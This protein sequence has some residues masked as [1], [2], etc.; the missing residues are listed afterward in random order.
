MTWEVCRHFL[1][2][3]MWGYWE[4]GRAFGGWLEVDEVLSVEPSWMGTAP[5]HRSR[6]NLLPRLALPWEDTVRRRL[7]ATRGRTVSRAEL[8]PSCHTWLVSWTVGSNCLLVMCHPVGG[9]LWPQPGLD[10]IRSCDWIGLETGLRRWDLASLTQIPKHGNKE[11]K[12][13]LNLD[14]LLDH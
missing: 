11:I 13:H 7:G 6:E 2:L 12:I 5:S 8:A 14:S 3:R 9:I 10:I 1:L 4:G